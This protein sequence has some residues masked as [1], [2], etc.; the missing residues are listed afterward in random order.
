MPSDSITMSVPAPSLTATLSPNTNAL[1]DLSNTILPPLADT[2]VKSSLSVVE[3]AT[4]KISS[5]AT[6][7]PAESSVRLPVD[8]SISFAPVT[9]T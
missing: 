6:V 5:T 1:S 8:V 2:R 9:P 7:P 4:V 3:P